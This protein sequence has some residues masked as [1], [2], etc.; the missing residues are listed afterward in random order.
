[1]GR[2]LKKLPAVCQQ[3]ILIFSSRAALSFTLITSW[4]PFF[5]SNQGKFL[6]FKNIFFLIS[7]DENVA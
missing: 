3:R 6:D 5:L 4:L 7:K 2:N 1:M